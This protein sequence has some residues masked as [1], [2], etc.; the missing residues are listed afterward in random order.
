MLPCAVACHY[1]TCMTARSFAVAGSERNRLPREHVNVDMPCGT[2]HDRV[3]R[4]G[5]GPDKVDGIC[6]S[7]LYI[8]YNCHCRHFY[9]ELGKGRTEAPS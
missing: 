3:D 4:V 5:H 7:Q 1:N 2:A 9:V 6:L 8:G